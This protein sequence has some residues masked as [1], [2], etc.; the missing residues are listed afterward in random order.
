MAE[1]KT[2]NRTAQSR[3]IRAMRINTEF[4]VTSEEMRQAA[5]KD[6]QA[7]FRGGVVEFRLKTWANTDGSFTIRAVKP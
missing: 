6:A 2:F 5:L 7:F 1:L 3:R 4:T